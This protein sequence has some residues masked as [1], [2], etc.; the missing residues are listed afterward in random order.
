MSQTPEI[1]Q[2]FGAW[3][4]TPATSLD[5][6]WRINGPW[7]GTDG[8][9]LLPSDAEFLTG[10]PGSDDG[11]VLALTVQPGVKQGAELQ[12]L[13]LG[14]FGYGYYEASMKIT[15]VPGAVVSFFAIQA[16]G[17]GPQEIDIEFLTNESGFASSASHV[18]YTLHP[19]G[20]TF[21]QP[22]P[23]DPTAGFHDYGFL[24]TPGQV[25]FTVDGTV[26]H[27]FT[28]PQLVLTPGTSEFVMANT[29]TG[30][31][32]WGGGPP[33]QPATSEYDWIKYFPNATT[34]LA[35]GNVITLASNTT[36]QASSGAE[37]VFAGP[38]GGNTVYGD[39]GALTF[40]NAAG[41]ST[42]FGGSGPVTVFAGAGGVYFGGSGG[43]N[44]LVGGAGAAT[45][46]AGGSGDLL[47]ANGSADDVLAAGSGNA[48][49][50]GAGSDTLFGGSGTDAINAGGGQDLIVGG[51]GANFVQLGSGGATVFAGAGFNRFSA[52][53]GHAGG[54]DLIIGFAPGDQ[55]ALTGYSSEASIT[56]AGGSTILTLSDGTQITLVGV[57]SLPANAI[58]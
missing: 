17:Y 25:Q 27:T 34:I 52:T 11:D 31:P 36:V 37:T 30:N 15:P 45:L 32:N 3:S 33:A 18:H 2:E 19:S 50:F 22:L 41:A 5:G 51:S 6:L 56:S 14:T 49:L 28:D 24:W 39:S 26:T 54:S 21:D 16:P 23:F 57:A 42:L 38:A 40:I 13:P 9:T 8:N 47:Y 29:W 20:M 10:Y 53:D 46:V 12:S 58:V 7:V 44:V 1:L 4:G 48:T 55:L 35:E 43:S